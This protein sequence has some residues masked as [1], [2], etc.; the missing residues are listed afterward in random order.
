MMQHLVRGLLAL[1][2]LA[3]AAT[4]LLPRGAYADGLVT[5]TGQTNITI[6]EDGATHVFLYTLTNNSGVALSDISTVGSDPFP[7]PSG[8]LSD[9]TG[10]AVAMV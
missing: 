1:G 3:L 6:S 7:L 8:E 9:S 4:L 2:L 5:F 10:G